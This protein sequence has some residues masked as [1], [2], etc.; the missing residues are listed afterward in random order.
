MYST[1][2]R[3]EI[4]LSALELISRNGFHGAPMAMI[5]DRSQVAQG[6][7]YRYFECKETLIFELHRFL[8]EKFEGA[9]RRNIPQGRP[10]R[11]R[12]FHV[13]RGFVRYCL[14]APLEFRFLEQFHN[15]P[16]GAAFRRDQIFGNTEGGV[17]H[18]LL[19]EG[20]R[21][22]IFKVLPPSVHCALIFGPLLCLVRDQILGFTPLDQPLIEHAIAACWDAIRA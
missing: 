19:E 13:G 10:L 8:I 18:E 14:A 21:E 3:T 22:K 2:K 1:D 9:L 5:A 15:S 17:I 16:Y 20:Q 7:I 6:T 11:E 12:F 4:M